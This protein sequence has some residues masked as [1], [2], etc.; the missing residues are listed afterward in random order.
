MIKMNGE[1]IFKESQKFKQLWV[2]LILSLYLF[3][4]QF[5]IYRL[6]SSSHDFRSNIA[7]YIALLIL[8]LMI[9]LFFNTRLDTLITDKGIYIKFK[10]FQ[11]KY[12]YYDWNSISDFGI[13]S[14]SSFKD[15]GGFG[16]RWNSETTAYLISGS[17]GLNLHFKNGKKVLVSTSNEYE[18]THVINRLKENI[19]K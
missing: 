13:I 1:I 14:Y 2:W 11:C 10:P 4:I 3:L 12:K 9:I 5:F 7:I 19:Q 16:I 17:R 6:I 8:I 15:F 18:L